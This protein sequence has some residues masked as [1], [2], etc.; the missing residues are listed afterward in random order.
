MT[1]SQKMSKAWKTVLRKQAARHGRCQVKLV[2]CMLREGKTKTLLTESGD[3]LISLPESRKWL[4]AGYKHPRS[5]AKINE[6]DAHFI[7]GETE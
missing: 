7:N 1:S 3:V 5:S 2:K 6:G 4:M